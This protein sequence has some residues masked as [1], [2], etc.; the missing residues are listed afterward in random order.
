MDAQV[1]GFGV[2]VTDA[3]T[4]TYILRTRYPGKSSPSRREIG[5]CDVLS[6]A[7]ARDIA[8]TW[9]SLVANDIDPAVK[10]QIER[11]ENLQRRETTFGHVA[12]R[13]IAEKLPGERKG[14]DVEREIRRELLPEWKTRPIDE[15]TDLDVLKV[16]KAKKRKGNVAARN[17]LALIKRF[18]RW[19]V[20]QR[21]YGLA[22]SPCL[23][24]QTKDIVGETRSRD[25]ILSD[26]ELFALWRAAGR[27]PSPYG[28]AYK[29]LVLTALRLREAGNASWNEFD[30]R[31]RLWII[32]ADRMKGKNDGKRQARAH[33]VP[34]TPQ[35]RELLEKLPKPKKG[36]FLFS[37]TAGKK[38]AWMG[39]KVKQRIDERMLR[40]L[41]A[42]GRLRREDPKS[43]HLPG[44]VNHDIRRTVRSHLSRLKIAEEAR[45]AVLAHVRP[46]IKSTYDHH[47]YLDEKREALQLWEA[48]LQS[49]LGNYVSPKTI[50]HN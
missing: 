32:P 45:E 41:R 31:N 3:G 19:A 39:A 9:R 25:R 12:E 40:T 36:N 10:E 1:P 18:F 5:K 6:L 20:G 4:R 22:V 44:W 48:R 2:R 46:G 34:I 30:L 11:A 23:A 17:L 7:D 21:V 43:I 16:I 38:P 14:G 26:D 50:A 24:L 37:T 27:L 13:F 15:I 49:I 33:A 28:P 47:D 8:R 42:L 35:I 29:M